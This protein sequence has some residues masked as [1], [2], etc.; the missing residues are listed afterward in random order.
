MADDFNTQ[1]DYSMRFFEEITKIKDLEEKQRMLK[2][3]LL[4]IGESLV[5]IKEET[6][7][8]ILEIKKDLEMIKQNIERLMSFLESASS[9][10]SKFA[11][12]EDLEI[13]SKQAKMFQPLDFVRK[14]DLEKFNVK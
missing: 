4:M 8:R 2:D 14:K 3:R 10:F 9:E 11:K 12:K 13:L 5:E 6:D 7:S 1:S